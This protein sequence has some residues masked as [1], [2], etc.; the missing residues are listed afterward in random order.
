MPS[1]PVL[2]AFLAATLALN[3]TPGAD[4]AYVIARSLGQGRKAGLIS[5]LAITAGCCVH[6]GLATIGLA[7]LLAKSPLAFRALQY[8]GAAY[9][10]FIAWRLLS[11]TPGERQGTA[12]AASLGRIF[13]Q[14]VVTNVL[15]PKVALFI[16]AFLPQFVDPG[17]GPAWVQML[18]L[19]ALF[20][21][22][23][24]MVNGTLALLATGAGRTVGGSAGA[25]WLR[26]ASAGI[27]ALLALRI[28]LG[29]RT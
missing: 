10:L 6:I 12:A 29:A 2:L 20:C 22:S 21:V 8:A 9:L 5:A 17:R 15:N 11:S 14:G 18:I 4:M 16:L 19:G 7:A 13:L 25:V 1:L 28:A 3:F 27:L 23:G 26:R 24:T